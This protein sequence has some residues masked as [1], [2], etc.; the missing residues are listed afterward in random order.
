ME[1]GVSPSRNQAYPQAGGPP[2][3]AEKKK[4][5]KQQQIP[6]GGRK[7]RLSERG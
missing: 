5:K 1:R 2:I 7:G 6:R 4:K 3:I